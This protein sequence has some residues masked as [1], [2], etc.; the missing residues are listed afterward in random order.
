M[1]HFIHIF[2]SIVGILLLGLQ[3]VLLIFAVLYG[4]DG[5]YQMEAFS[6]WMVLLATIGEDMVDFIKKKLK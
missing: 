4:L 6:L 3:I 1:K 2:L 5:K